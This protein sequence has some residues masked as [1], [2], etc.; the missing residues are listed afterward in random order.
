MGANSKIQWCD[1]SFN[2]WW[3][4]VRV[5]PAC[6]FC[7]ADTQAARYG[8]QLWRAN[9]ERRMLSDQHWRQPLKWNREAQAA[10][11]PALVFCASM[12]DVFEDR[13]DLDAPRHRLWQLIDNTPWLTWQLLTKR[14]ENV[15]RLAPWNDNWPANIWLG[16]SVET[17]RFAEQ[18]IPVLLDSPAKLHFL[19]CEP[20][21]G[22]VDLIPWAAG[23]P[24]VI[25]GGESGPKSRPTNLD[26]F[27]DLRD[28]C[29]AAGTSLFVKQLG[30]V[31]AKQNS[32]TSRKAGEPGEWPE[33][34]RIR[35]MP[36]AAGG[37]M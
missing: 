4:C 27:R 20:L 8:H 11:R 17:Q 16:T 30:T 28:Q 7:Y 1:H 37:A 19:S 2:P 18:R 13:R 25:A 15:A 36:A 29:A 10:G 5:S 32:A 24:W 34:L 23:I 12:A 9:G 6:R 31:W 35:Q 21:L 14:P 33:D 3:G 26:W 22:P